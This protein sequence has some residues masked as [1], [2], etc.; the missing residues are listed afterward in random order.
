MVRDRSKLIEFMLQEGLLFK[1]TQVCISKCSMSEILIKENHNGGLARIFG[2][3]ET[4]EELK[5]F[6]FMHKMRTYVHKFVSTCMI[7]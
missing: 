1:N 2:H 7:C 6:Y 5:H 3:E 4:Y